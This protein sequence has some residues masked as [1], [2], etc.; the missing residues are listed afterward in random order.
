ME[1]KMKSAALTN[2]SGPGSSIA[3]SP[4]SIRV[5]D[6]IIEKFIDKS[7]DELNSFLTSALDSERDEAKRIGILAARLYI[8]RMRISKISEFN[9]NGMIP[10][11]ETVSPHEL[12]NTSQ[13]LDESLIE[14]ETLAETSDQL[15]EWNELLTIEDGEVN[16]VRIPS[17][18][19]ITVGKEDAVRLIETGKAKMIKEDAAAEEP[20][21]EQDLLPDAPA[22][23]DGELEAEPSA[24]AKA[25]QS[26]EIPADADEETPE[27]SLEDAGM[28]AAENT[29]DLTEP[30]AHEPS[31]VETEQTPDAVSDEVEKDET[32][33]QT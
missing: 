17:G 11:I 10:A 32:S 4:T 31:S 7:L 24:D 19:A 16:G 33:P 25:E 20:S 1:K 30:E 23:P 18:V 28:S 9:Q 13:H 5:R 3:L 15:V 14:D 8:L 27:F 26:G 6:A 22:M 21:S 29:P 2:G 12:V